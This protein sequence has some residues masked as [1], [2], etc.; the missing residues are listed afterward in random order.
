MW[1]VGSGCAGGVQDGELFRGQGMTGAQREHALTAGTGD[2]EIPDFEAANAELQ[3]GFEIVGLMGQ[4]IGEVWSRLGVPVAGHEE[5]A[6]QLH[7]PR[8]VRIEF[9]RMVEER[10]GG[11]VF[12]ELL[13]HEA[14]VQED[15]GVLGSQ[16]PGHVECEAGL[17]QIPE[18]KVLFAESEPR[19]R[20]L[21][22]RGGGKA[23][24]HRLPGPGCS[25]E[26][27]S[28]VHASG[29]TGFVAE[30]GHGA[31][32]RR[33]GGC[34]SSASALQSSGRCGGEGSRNPWL[35]KHCRSSATRWSRS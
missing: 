34:G 16:Y 1:S 22:L 5:G 29:R 19:Q 28:G 31:G 7:G 27:K 20:V 12:V 33:C 17:L 10:L 23:R 25:G 8:I 18:F 4:E 9:E 2:V 26:V 15:P 32:G 3:E 35:T 21:R 14:K 24:F 6:E 11:V 13:M 30:W